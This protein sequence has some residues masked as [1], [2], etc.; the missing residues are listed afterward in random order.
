MTVMMEDIRNYL[1]MPHV[2]TLEENI[3]QLKE[4]GDDIIPMLLEIIKEKSFWEQSGSNVSMGWP[5]NYQAAVHALVKLADKQSDKVYKVLKQQILT[6]LNSNNYSTFNALIPEAIKALVGLNIDKNEIINFLEMLEIKESGV[7]APAARRALDQLRGMKHEIHE[8]I[9]DKD[10]LEKKLSMS[11]DDI[12]DLNHEGMTPLINLLYYCNKINVLERVKLLVEKGGANVNAR[13]L[14]GDTALHPAVLRHS[15]EVVEYL[16]KK[17]A[18][19]NV[20]RKGNKDITP[21]YFALNRWRNEDEKKKRLSLLREYGAKIPEDVILN[22][23]MDLGTI[24]TQTLTPA[25]QPFS[26]VNMG[27]CTTDSSDHENRETINAAYFENAFSKKKGVSRISW[28]IIICIWAFVFSQALSVAISVVGILM[29][30][31]GIALIIN[32]IK[33]IYG[34][35]LDGF[36]DRLINGRQ[37]K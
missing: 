23:K 16:L 6:H 37:R 15:I 24:S 5:E 12:E 1:S 18:D 17:G 7:Q 31:L 9:H 20:E 21:V 19:P 22:S 29:G 3:N 30:I 13:A 14:N 36:L 10:K 4:Y 32:G 35:R 26:A 11:Q 34:K 27:E 33:K 28:G 2:W 8:C 25:I